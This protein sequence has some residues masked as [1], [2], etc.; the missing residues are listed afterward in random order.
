ML[1]FQLRYFIFSLVLFMVEVFIALYVHDGFIRPY[2]G[3]FLVVILLY[4]LVRTFLHARVMPVAVSVLVFSF[5]VEITQ[6]FHLV[7]L[8][9]WQHNRL[10]LIVL[11]SSF[12]LVDLVCYTLGIVLVILIEKLINNPKMR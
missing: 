5:F 7:S 6:Y 10:A 8:L 1:T 4:C 11:G 3:D 12:S 2:A 9:G